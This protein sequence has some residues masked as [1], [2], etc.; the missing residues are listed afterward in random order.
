MKPGTLG[1]AHHWQYSEERMTP[2][3]MRA[4]LML[5]VVLEIAVPLLPHILVPVS[6]IAPRH[7]RA[8]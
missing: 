1:Y 6:V 2:G 3:R 4:G 5:V 8:R 7:A